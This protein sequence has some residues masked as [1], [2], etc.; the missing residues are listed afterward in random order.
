MDGFNLLRPGFP[1]QWPDTA[2]VLSA[3][4]ILTLPRGQISGTYVVQDEV[5]HYEGV[6]VADYLLGREASVFFVTRCPSLAPLMQPALSAVPALERLSATRRFQLRTYAR[7]CAI[8]PG[9]VEVYSPP[10]GV[11]AIKSKS[12][13]LISHNA[14]ARELFDQLQGRYSHPN[15]QII[16]DANS[17]RFL[18][19]AIREGNLAGRTV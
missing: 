11:E 4:E 8:K 2:S 13:V 15:L 3:D 12:V 9:V 10:L 18:D 19:T 14:P 6:A 5:G 16:G 1:V 17:P 7:I